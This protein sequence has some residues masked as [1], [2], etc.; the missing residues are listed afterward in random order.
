MDEEDTEYVDLRCGWR[1]WKP[2]F[3]QYFNNPKWFLFFF[4][5]FSCVQGK[6][7]IVWREYIVH[8][9]AIKRYVCACASRNDFRARSGFPV[10]LRRLEMI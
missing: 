7:N 3:I 8:S 9:T 1:S 6:I 10:S 4:T 2:K 5:V